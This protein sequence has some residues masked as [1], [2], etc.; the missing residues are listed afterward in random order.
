MRGARNQVS[1]ALATLTVVCA[2]ASRSPPP[3]APIFGG[4]GYEE[5]ATVAATRPPDAIASKPAEPPPT[6]AQLDAATRALDE[7]E[8]RDHARVVTALRALADALA[9]VAPERM[10]LVASVRANADKLERSP[11]GALGHADLVRIALDDARNVFAHGSPH[12]RW[13]IGPYAR[14]VS[15]YTDA[16]T[17]IDPNRP[18][19]EQHDQVVTAFEDAVSAL[20]LA[21]GV[22]VPVPR[23]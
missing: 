19:L 4:L 9:L 20:E 21:A 16:V 2:C 23:G 1:A 12:S 14:A 3:E 5:H 11:E 18:L 10:D 15:A 7:A 6:L 17:S 13:Q 22:V 8:S